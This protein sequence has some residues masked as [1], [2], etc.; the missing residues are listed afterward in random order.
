M[1]ST[2]TLC[3]NELPQ[4]DMFSS[5]PPS[6][7]PTVHRHV[8]SPLSYETI[9]IQEPDSYVASVV[10]IPR[11]PMNTVVIGPP[12]RTHA[13]PVAVPPLRVVRIPMNVVRFRRNVQQSAK[14]TPVRIVGQ[15]PFRL[16]PEVLVVHGVVDV[17]LAKVVGEFSRRREVVDVYVRVRRK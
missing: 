10:G 11:T 9:A 4:P 16:P 17:E 1:T 13:A 7:H 3:N 14:S 2:S 12:G 15:N 6:F 5:S 8:P